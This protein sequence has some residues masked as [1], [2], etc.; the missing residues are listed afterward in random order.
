MKNV[1]QLKI[2]LTL[3]V[4]AV[5]LGGCAPP[6]NG[7]LWGKD[8]TLTP[9]WSRLGKAAAD[10]ALAPETWAPLAGAAVFWA[11]GLDH[12][13]SDWAMDHHP[14]FGSQSGARNASD[15][16]LGASMAAYAAT[17]LAVPSGEHPG[18]WVLN[19]TK[20]GVVGIAAFSATEGLT[21]LHKDASGRKRPDN[22][23]TDSF[24]SGHASGSA[25]F[26]TLASRNLEYLP[27][28]PF[29]RTVARGGLA[30]L[31]AGTAWARVEAGKH[32]PSDVLAGAAIGHFFGAF[33]NDAFLAP[34]SPVTLATSVDL[35]E[36]RGLITITWRY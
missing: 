21:S 35:P 4:L 12:S 7:H 6:P 25:V 32:F 23:D 15:Y 26:T 17:G 3:L 5:L 16:L 36:K 2:S 30:A 33:L 9:G 29:Q 24:P 10:A 34:G 1:L 28:S 13:V 27:L 20:G 18:E 11:G 22:S 31:T 14:L 8:V 19:K